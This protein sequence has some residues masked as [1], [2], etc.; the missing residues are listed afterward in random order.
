V[1]IL[2]GLLPIC[3]YC[4]RIRD[5]RDYWREVESYVR[6]QAPVDFSH[7]ICPRCMA[8]RFPE[9]ARRIIDEALFVEGDD[10]E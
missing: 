7:G 3:G 4:K 2:S 5:D 1:R 10:R 6:S 9:Q 8:E